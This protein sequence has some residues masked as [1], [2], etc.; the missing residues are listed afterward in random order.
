MKYFSESKN[1]KTLKTVFKDT[2]K[3]YEGKEK[4]AL[5]TYVQKQH[6]VFESDKKLGDGGVKHF[7]ISAIAPDSYEQLSP[8]QKKT[9]ENESINWS[10]NTFE[11]FGFIGALEYNQDKSDVQYP[12]FENT[13]KGFHIHMAVSGK[14]TIRGS[15]DLLSLRESLANHLSNTIDGDMRTVLGVKNKEEMETA[16]RE[17]ISKKQK[18]N[19][20]ENLKNNPEFMENN[21]AI[22]ELNDDLSKVF[23]VL[24]V[25]HELKNDLISMNKNERYHILNRK[26]DLKNEMGSIKKDIKG[27]QNEMKF[28]DKHIKD[29]KEKITAVEELFQSEY[30]ELQSFY[31]KKMMGF[32]YWADGEHGWFRKMKND[33]LKNKEITTSEFLAQV[34][35]NKSYWQ[36]SKSDERKR[37][38]F[39][40]K[41]KRADFK[42][43]LFEMGDIIRHYGRDRLFVV[44]I[45]SMDKNKLDK[46]L[47]QYSDIGTKYN[48]HYEVFL[49]RIEQIA[50]E[51][52]IVRAQKSQLVQKKLAKTNTKR[53]M[54]EKILQFDATISS[55]GFEALS[56]GVEK[57]YS[58]SITQGD[59]NPDSIDEKEK[60][61]HIKNQKSPSAFSHL[62]R[63]IMKITQFNETH[64]LK[65]LKTNTL[66]KVVKQSVYAKHPKWEQTLQSTRTIDDFIV[67]F[68][69][70]KSMAKSKPRIEENFFPSL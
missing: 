38:Q 50:K 30:K 14:Y 39:I 70:L 43:K 66:L 59:K 33:Q 26:S 55:K 63:G 8:A 61:I 51:I 58:L 11:K 48:N 62:L 69:N 21:Q 44:S 5:I 24:G 68:D 49:K 1:L 3:I 16:R 40:L 17:S 56:K 25:K 67:I 9:L 34:A 28:I 29:E 35:Q 23:N 18:Q 42:K 13:K 4:T 60:S 45:V 19:A 36:W 54:I 46:K 2:Q 22:Q 15:G 64:I 47:A 10:K 27:R 53:A 20:L 7:I 32:S 41:Q 6:N 31:K 12:S 52:E 65:A 37:H 57:K